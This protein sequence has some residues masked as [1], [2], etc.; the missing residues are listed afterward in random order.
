[1]VRV[2]WIVANVGFEELPKYTQLLFVVYSIVQFVTVV[3]LPFFFSV[4]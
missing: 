2:L 4:K 1:M 3:I